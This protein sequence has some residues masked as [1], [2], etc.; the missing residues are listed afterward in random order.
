MV[1]PFFDRFSTN[2]MSFSSLAAIEI[3][4]IP[5][6]VRDMCPGFRLSVIYHDCVKHYHY[7]AL[8]NLCTTLNAARELI[9]E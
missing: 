6:P 2:G 1:L 4:F 5:H 7:Q 8:E 3:L 9:D